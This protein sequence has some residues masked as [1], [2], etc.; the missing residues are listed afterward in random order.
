M[1]LK[2]AYLCNGFGCETKCGLKNDHCRH[3]TDETHTLIKGDHKFRRV[4]DMY[5]ESDPQEDKTKEE[6]S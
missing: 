1:G 3:T 5:S 2:R 6:V 4:G